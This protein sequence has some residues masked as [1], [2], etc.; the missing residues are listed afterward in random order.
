MAIDT[1][2]EKLMGRKHFRYASWT[3]AVIFFSASVTN[4]I[5]F[6]LLSPSF[7]Q[8]LN[9]SHQSLGMLVGYYFVA[10]S[11]G[12]LTLGSLLG[13]I[14]P[15]YLLGISAVL[16]S[17]GCVIFASSHS[18]GT[19]LAG[20]LLVALG[21]SSSFLGVIYVIGRDLPKKFSL[22][23]AV[24]QGLANFAAASLSL[25]IGLFDTEVS[26]REPYFIA[27]LFLICLAV[28]LFILI[29]NSQKSSR[30]L[31][32]KKAIQFEKLNLC[33]KSS[34]FWLALTFYSCLFGVIIAYSDLWNIQFQVDFF[35]ETSKE[36]ALL[37]TMIS[38]GIIIGSFIVGAWSQYRGDYVLPARTFSFLSII[39]VTALLS[40][41]LS[42]SW[43]LA[44]NFL[45]GF[46]LS[47]SIL[48]L[49]IVQS[50]LPERTHAIASAL[51][52][53]GGFALGGVIQTLIGLSLDQDIE[54]AYIRSFSDLL[55]RLFDFAP[56]PTQK[57]YNYQAG[58]QLIGIVVIV[59][60]ISSLLLS[61][62]KLVKR[63]SPKIGS[64]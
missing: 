34:A 64:S 31:S 28:L 44:A 57:F 26:F 19:A 55:A 18:F 25:F 46:G 60:C 24:S 54:F 7:T 8:E 27:A 51:I 15:R 5:L 12:Q 4:S 43:T 42:D 10:Y 49:S 9:L 39:A 33:F 63:R 62:K 29:G 38:M 47:S 41:N 40:I 14:S 1:G 52:V 22:M 36:S 50:E 56:Q 58:F 17:S 48:S 2:K 37:N 59:G 32:V 61:S 6:A 30:E 16:A 53:T 3:I 11:I 35:R 21:L 20:Q 45:L 13:P 23:A